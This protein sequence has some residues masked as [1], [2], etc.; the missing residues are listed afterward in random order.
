MS[1]KKNNI[2]VKNLDRSYLSKDFSSLK[3][4][5]LEHVSIYYPDKIRDFSEPSVGGM[6][7]D[8]A[9]LVGDSM[10]YY[11]DHQFREMDPF[12]SV[13][14]DNIE[15]H[16]R[17]AGVKVFA[18]S[19]ATAEIKVTIKVPAE[20]FNSKWRPKLSCLPVIL[21]G[22]EFASDS[23]IIFNLLEDLDFSRLDVN[24]NILAN[25]TVDS[26]DNFGNPSIFNVSISTIAVSGFETTDSFQ[27]E[28]VHVPFR[29]LTLSKENVSEIISVVDS[30]NNPY[31]EVES[32]SQ[33][34]V[35]IEV[36]N[37]NFGKDLIA[38]NLEI[39]PAPRRFVSYTSPKTRKTTLRFGSG[40][41]SSLDDDVIPDPSE[42]TLPLYGKN[43]FS[44]F[45]IDPNLLLQSQTLG[46]S[47]K[48]TTIRVRYRHGGGTLHNVD[49][50]TIINLPTLVIDFRRN[51]SANEAL[52]V[53]KNI[54]VNNETNAKGGKNAPTYDE[55]KSLIPS[56]R[57]AQNRIVTR[58]DLLSRIYTMPSRFGKVYRASISNNPSNPLSILIYLISLNLEDKL[59]LTPDAFKLNLSS[60]LNEFRLISDSYDI[61][62]ARI[63]NYNI[64]YEVYLDKKI[65]KQA[66]IININNNIANALDKK[67][68]HIDQPFIID[69]VSN[70]IMNSTGVLSVS[71]L[72][73]SSKF[74]NISDRQYSNYNFNFEANTKKGI[75]R[76]PVGSIFEMRYPE[77]DIVGSAI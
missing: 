72:K 19:P 76:G 21:K 1:L 60:Y 68:F 26:Y 52:F 15:M 45:S 39:L 41:I 10:S 49:T 63:I 13:E 42:L 62:D 7:M 74:G 71:N 37:S 30:F 11:M 56:A 34:T 64:N 73:I 38:K 24:Q 18:A 43:T 31:Y 14:P 44:R 35:F 12:Q 36:E 54:T 3:F 59:D 65:N 66:A 75:I 33:D 5:L 32:L 2:G 29:E 69:D 27:I 6:L 58:Q 46:L 8:L 51:P 57:N 17:N 53:R 16:L 61:L 22:T 25:Y 50:D 40:N 28:D 77:Y 47:P 23:G 20:Q 55:L 48:N 70:I 67:F 4:D 9:A